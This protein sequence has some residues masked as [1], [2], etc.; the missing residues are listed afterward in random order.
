MFFTWQVPRGNGRESASPQGDRICEL[1]PIRLTGT[2][3]SSTASRNEPNRS[4][5]DKLFFGFCEYY[6]IRP[7]F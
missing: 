5:C 2:R 4:I 7:N 1:Y 6:I 3:K